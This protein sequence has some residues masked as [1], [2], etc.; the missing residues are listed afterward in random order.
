MLADEALAALR[1]AGDA[2]APA[3]I[4]AARFFAEN[5]TTAAGG[6]AATVTEGAAAIPPAGAFG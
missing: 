3:R 6:L 5:L 4:A 2:D 1:L